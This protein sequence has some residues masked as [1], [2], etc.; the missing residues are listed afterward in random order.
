MPPTNP[1]IDAGEDSLIALLTDARGEDR[2]T[3]YPGVANKGSNT[4]DLGAYE[5]QLG[6]DLDKS[7]DVDTVG[8]TGD[9]IT[10]T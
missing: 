3:D 4:I 10:Y 2:T 1:A 7:A 5:I 6:L 8:L 9:Q